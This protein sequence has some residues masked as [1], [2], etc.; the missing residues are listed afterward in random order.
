MSE[1]KPTT[2]GRRN[3]GRPFGTLTTEP[4]TLVARLRAARGLAQVD[5]G[6]LIG[7]R[8]QTVR[9]YE[10]QSVIPIKGL[11]REK[12]EEMALESGISID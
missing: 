6:A 1:R 7:V 11:T 10:K 4:S 2:D 9:K 8:D 5:F 12:L 3:N